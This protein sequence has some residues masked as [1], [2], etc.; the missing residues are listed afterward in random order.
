MERTSQTFYTSGRF[1]S[2]NQDDRVSVRPV[3]VDMTTVERKTE[4]DSVTDFPTTNPCLSTDVL[5]TE[6]PCLSLLFRSTLDE[7]IYVIIPSDH[8]IVIFLTSVVLY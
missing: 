3:S 1:R 6:T 4:M 5:Y 2:I 7:G 8:P